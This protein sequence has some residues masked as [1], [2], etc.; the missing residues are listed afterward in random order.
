MKCCN[1]PKLAD[2]K[3]TIRSQTLAGD[4]YGGQSNTWSTEAVIWAWIRPIPDFNVSEQFKS[5]QLQ[6]TATHKVIIRYNSSFKDVKSFAANSISFDSR[7]FNVLSIKNFD[8]TL[9]NY[10]T[11]F[12]EMLIVDNGPEVTNG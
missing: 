2:Q 3:I 12:Q 4:N 11:E 1:F 10:G 9:K 8:K 6:S 7:V 5:D